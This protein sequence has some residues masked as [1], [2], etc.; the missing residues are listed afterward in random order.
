MRVTSTVHIDN[1]PV[2][3]VRNLGEFSSIQVDDMDGFSDVS[4]LLS[5]VPYETLKRAVDA[6]NNVIAKDMQKEAAE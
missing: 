2:L 4:L 1:I 5:T 3:T 6:F